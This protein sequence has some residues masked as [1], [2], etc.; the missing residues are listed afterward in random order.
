MRARSL[1]AVLAVASVIGAGLATSAHAQQN[2]QQ[3]P[4]FTGDPVKVVYIG[5]IEVA[6]L[7]AKQPQWP[8]AVRARAKAIN[9]EGGIEDASVRRTRSR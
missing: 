9:A 3:K 1:C 8:A 4:K 7:G 6:A 5:E 2:Q